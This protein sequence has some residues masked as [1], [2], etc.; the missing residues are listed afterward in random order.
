MSNEPINRLETDKTL[1]QREKRKEIIKKFN[2][3][4]CD[5]DQDVQEF[6]K[7]LRESTDEDE[8]ESD[9]STE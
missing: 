8:Q 5:S 2:T 1:A 7:Y 4:N 3:I 9:S 6:L